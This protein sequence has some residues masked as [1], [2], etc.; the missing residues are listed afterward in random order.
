[1]KLKIT[2]TG[3]PLKFYYNGYGDLYSG[4]SVTGTI[5][6]AVPGG[7]TY[8]KGFKCEEAPPMVLT[9]SDSY[10]E[11]IKNPAGAP[12]DSAVYR[13]EKGS[14]LPV[15]VS[16]INDI[17]GVDSLIAAANKYD[18]LCLEKNS[19][20]PNYVY[21]LCEAVSDFVWD[22][23]YNKKNFDSINKALKTENSYIRSK[24]IEAL[25]TLKDPRGM[26]VLISIFEDEGS[27]MD[28]S[29]REAVI[30]ALG[31]FKDNRVISLLIGEF[32]NGFDWNCVY[33]LEKI[34]KQ[35]SEPLISSLRQALKNE[36]EKTINGTVTT[37]GR[38]K[39]KKAIPLIIQSL[40]YG[41][42]KKLPEIIYPAS[43]A[44]RDITGQDFG[45]NIDG[46]EK[47]WQRNKAKK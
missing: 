9:C 37:L 24:A 20:R 19:T 21:P 1:M 18:H 7:K 28:G 39:E 38:I 42:E 31:M 3:Q 46:W 29:T 34:G 44:L 35:A 8:S 26:N 16:M 10:I 12:F 25:G 13:V 45:E 23:A 2:L 5:T 47:W 36:D 40:K 30:K 41:L 32:R 33:A 6:F 22:H 4:A 43:G 15:F 14:F 17:Y 27:K 11:K